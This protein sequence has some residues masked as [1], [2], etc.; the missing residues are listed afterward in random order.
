MPLRHYFRLQVGSMHLQK[1]CM[2]EVERQ[3]PKARRT[4]A[5]LGCLQDWVMVS[6]A[7]P[8]LAIHH[9]LMF[10]RMGTELNLDSVLISRVIA[11]RQPAA[12]VTMLFQSMPMF[13]LQAGTMPC[14]MESWTCSR[15]T[16]SC[17][18]LLL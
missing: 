10:P 18:S 14:R 9:G 1:G 11:S 2:G 15:Q 4:N 8:C 6:V 3:R 17:A 13:N 12:V 5:I 16:S 7:L